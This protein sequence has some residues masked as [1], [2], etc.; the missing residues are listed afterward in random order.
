MA[1]HTIIYLNIL[2]SILYASKVTKGPRDTNPAPM[3]RISELIQLT[4][5]YFVSHLKKWLLMHHQRDFEFA[6]HL[7]VIL[8]TKRFLF[9]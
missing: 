8:P 6:N 2:P 1:T 7:D 3:L 9:F 5:H 4:A